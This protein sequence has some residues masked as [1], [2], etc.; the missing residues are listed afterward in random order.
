LAIQSATALSAY[1]TSATS[2]PL[3]TETDAQ[4]A[5]G[6]G[7]S[8]AGGGAVGR[9]LARPVAPD[10]LGETGSTASTASADST[11]STDSTDSGS[12]DP[13]MFAAY[14]SNARSVAIRAAAGSVSFYA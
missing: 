6:D 4:A 14:G 5:S 9:A 3:G 10:A 7:A 11:D 1:L 12:A 8:S 2:A 13:V